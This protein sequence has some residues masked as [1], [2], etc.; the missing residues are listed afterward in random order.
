VRT[1][2]APLLGFALFGAIFAA[3]YY[4]PDEEQRQLMDP[5]FRVEPGE[6][7]QDRLWEAA[8]G[9][10]VTVNITVTRGGP[11]GVFI[12]HIDDLVEFVFNGTIHGADLIDDALFYEEYSNRN[13][14]S[15]YNF[16]FFAPGTREHVLMYVSKVPRPDGYENMTAEE[17][18]PYIT[19]IGVQIR[20]TESETKSLILGYIFA[21]PSV[22]L[23][24][25]AFWQKWRRRG[26]PPG[27]SPLSLPRDKDL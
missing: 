9:E 12:V 18:E 10:N 5:K 13:I 21:A 3:V 27:G 19:D 4:A 25:A 16:T 8:P 14:T 11:V 17:R 24:T 20:Y 15:T 26:E 22:L 7:K 1:L 2:I 23:V 6:V